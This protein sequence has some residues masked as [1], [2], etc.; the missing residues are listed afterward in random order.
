MAYGIFIPWP[1]LKSMPPA[2]KEWS[3]NHWTTREVPRIPLWRG[4]IWTKRE[5]GKGGIKGKGKYV[6]IGGKSVSGRGNSMVT[7]SSSGSKLGTLLLL[8][9]SRFSHVRLCAI[10]ETAVHQA[11]PSL[12]FSRQEHWSGLPFPSPMPHWRH[13]KL[14][15]W[16]DGWVG[17]GR[18]REQAGARSCRVLW[19]MVRIWISF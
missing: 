8:L 7:L 3:L 6:M 15:G 17:R 16:V 13:P 12:G 2:E 11:T 19:T 9:L 14:N 18:N 4:N 10:P 5:K 1:G